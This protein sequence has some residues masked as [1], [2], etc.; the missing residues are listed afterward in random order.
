MG[1]RITVSQGSGPGGEE[2][3]SWV[4]EGGH[5]VQGGGRVGWKVLD[6][7]EVSGAGE[8]GVLQGL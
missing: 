8:S 5:E 2:G 6:E 4:E 7:K 3:W 1:G